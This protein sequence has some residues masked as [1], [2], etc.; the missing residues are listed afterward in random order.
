MSPGGEALATAQ[1][2]ADSRQAWRALVEAASAPYRK[3]DNYAWRFARGK[4]GGDP[5]FRHVL[6]RG[7]IAPHARVLDL[8]CGQ[9]LLAS[10]LRA[11]AAAAHAGRWPDG[12]AAAPIGARVTGIELMAHDVARAETALGADA[13][14]VCAD[15]RLAELP[16]ADAVVIFD[17]LHYIGRAEQ[18][19]VLA[20]A[21][22]ALREGGT[23]L[24][25]IGDDG[26]R[27]RYALG[28]WI[29]RIT[30]GLR[31][32]G[33]RPLAG[34]PVAEWIATLSALGFEVRARPMSGRPPFA[35][36]L[37]VARVPGGAHP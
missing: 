5:V 21:R 33:F 36:Q 22:R 4:L 15:M 12:W 26:A 1:P 29:D 10:L 28:L 20:R 31:G 24:L 27:G 23:L 14:F 16:A 37:L 7:L 25:R 19:D 9:G 11:A 32:G 35:N 13:V 6:E 18:D 3:A 30:M 17:A 2:T 34:R 8:G